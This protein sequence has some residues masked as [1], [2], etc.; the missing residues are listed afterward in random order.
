M[1][2]EDIFRGLGLDAV[3][4]VKLLDWLDLSTD[5][6]QIPQRFSKLQAVIGF[7]KDVPEDTQRFLIAKATRGKMVDKL[8][9]MYEYTGLLNEKKMHE[10]KLGEIDKERSILELSNEPEL[11]ID[12]AKR[13]MDVRGNLDKIKEEIYLYEK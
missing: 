10:D 12:A 5:E 9:H 6:L 2:T 3:T 4:G 8:D 11:V 7:L 13:S 1:N